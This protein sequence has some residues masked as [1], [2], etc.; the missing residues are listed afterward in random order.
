MI[1]KIGKR[2]KFKRKAKNSYKLDK[3]S[4]TRTSRVK[5]KLRF[6]PSKSEYKS[7]RKTFSRSKTKFCSY[8]IQRLKSTKNRHIRKT[9]QKVYEES[10]KRCRLHRTDHRVLQDLRVIL[11]L[12]PVSPPFWILDFGFWKIFKT[13]ILFQVDR[14]EGRCQAP[15]HR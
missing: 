8:Q 3:K 9:L 10:R 12:P 7:V 2:R 4:Q 11:R 14:V 5:I 15:R 6:R 13:S 1:S